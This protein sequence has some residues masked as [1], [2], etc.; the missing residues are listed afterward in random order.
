MKHASPH[1]LVIGLGNPDRGDDGVG[2]RV[3]HQL[4]GRLPDAVRIL[5]RRGDLLSLID[6]WA[7][8]EALIC[9]DA[10]APQGAPGRIHRIDLT[11]DALPRDPTATSSHALG[12]PEAIALARTLGRAPSR[13]LVYAIEG[14]RFDCGASLTPAVAA[15]AGIVASRVV[16]DCARLAGLEGGSAGTAQAVAPG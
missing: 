14:C 5:T 7:D 15:A 13:I 11:R 10:A 8:V 2:A 6:D 1:P 4:A 12:L 16:E 9:I 3:A